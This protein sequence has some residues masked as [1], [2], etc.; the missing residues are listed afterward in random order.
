MIASLV[1]LPAIVSAVTSTMI[2]G[3]L[4]PKLLDAWLLQDIS[5]ITLKFVPPVFQ[6]AKS[7]KS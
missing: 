5:K 6:D 4:T 3:R 7:V 2:T 1:T